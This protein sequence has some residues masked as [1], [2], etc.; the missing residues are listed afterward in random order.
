MKAYIRENLVNRCSDWLI[1]FY[2]GMNVGIFYT[3]ECDLKCTREEKIDDLKGNI[4]IVDF[5]HNKIK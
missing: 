5:H 4:M 3:Q 2:T 1:L